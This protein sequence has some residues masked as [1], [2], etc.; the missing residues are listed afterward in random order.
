M[1][2]FPPERG[3]ATRYE[4]LCWWLQTH[5]FAALGILISGALVLLCVGGVSGFF[6]A[7]VIDGDRND[8]EGECL[9]ADRKAWYDLSIL[10]MQ[11][12]ATT[13]M[14]TPIGGWVESGD[15]NAPYNQYP[16][17]ANSSLIL[18]PNSFFLS[19][20]NALQSGLLLSGLGS[21]NISS[22]IH[23]PPKFVT[24]TNLLALDKSRQRPRIHFTIDD[25]PT[26]EGFP[27][28]LAVLER[29]N[30]TV[31]F[32]LVGV[33]IEANPSLAREALQAGHHLASHSYS[34]QALNIL[35]RQQV[36]AEVDKAEIALLT[37]DPSFN[38]TSRTPLR[39]KLFRPSYGYLTTTSLEVLDQRGYAAVMWGFDSWDWAHPGQSQ[40]IVDWVC[41]H[42]PAAMPAGG[43]LL[44]HQTATTA[45]ALP[46]IAACLSEDFD[47]VPSI[48][49]V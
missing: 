40:R 9:S 29:I 45:E 41:G 38:D 35:D 3:N 46:Q 26:P 22:S 15:A 7:S 33:S 25:G 23:S 32:F 11:T 39:R 31:T 48:W 14:F 49:D 13:S 1:P 42:A 19:Y 12:A 34:H 4:R 20:S 2:F 17:S 44:F 18:M 8:G 28:I 10:V 6:L 43:L 37:I 47:I 21:T 16:A 5:P 30:V 27:P 24:E 36:E